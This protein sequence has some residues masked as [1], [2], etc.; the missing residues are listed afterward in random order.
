MTRLNLDLF[1]YLRMSARSDL[2]NLRRHFGP[3]F[4]SVES[5]VELEGTPGEH[6][7]ETASDAILEDE[8]VAALS[9]IWDRLA[10][11]FPEFTDR[12][13]VWLLVE[14]ERNT[15]EY[16]AVLGIL[17]LPREERAKEVKRHKDRVKVTL[18]RRI[19]ELRLSE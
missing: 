11:L 19:G 7:V 3:E 12:Q 14:G 17:E 6:I 5:A 1:G 8:D 18:G 9:P 15:D 16:A 10:V 4:V 2:L 13:I